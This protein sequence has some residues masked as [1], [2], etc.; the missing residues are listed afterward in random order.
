L[1]RNREMNDNTNEIEVD[2]ATKKFNETA[3]DIGKLLIS[4]ST[5]IVV[6]SVSF[7]KSL[8]KNNLEYKYILISGWI[9]EIVSIILGTAFLFSMLRV[10]DI[11]HDIKTYYKP[12]IILGAMQYLT[13]I[14]GLIALSV[15]TG[16]NLD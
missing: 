15:F 10:Y 4:L 6:L 9:L 7:Q 2:E 3:Y 12:A 1:T 8:L 14:L 11:W 5:G 13:F 16:L